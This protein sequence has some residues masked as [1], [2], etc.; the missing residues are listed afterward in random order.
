MTEHSTRCAPLLRSLALR[1]HHPKL[2]SFPYSFTIIRLKHYL[3][4][5]SI[6]KIQKNHLLPWQCVRSQR[7]DLSARIFPFAAQ[8]RE[9]KWDLVR[10]FLVYEYPGPYNVTMYL[11]L[12]T[13]GLAPRTPAPGFHPYIDHYSTHLI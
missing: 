5:V 3:F 4:A 6:S 2:T 1:H 7:I 13:L 9:R 8:V 11:N 10:S 12:K